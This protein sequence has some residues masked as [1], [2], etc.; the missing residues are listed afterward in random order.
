MYCVTRQS[1]WGTGELVVE[2]SEGGLDYTNPDAL[3]AKYKGEFQEFS[4]PREAVDTAIRIGEEWQKVEPIEKILIAMGCTSGNTIPFEGMEMTPE[5]LLALK[6]E[7]KK[8]WDSL[9]KCAQCGKV[10]GEEKFGMYALYNCCSER[11]AERW[12]ADHVEEEE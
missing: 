8:I 5:N 10:M 3:S 12:F 11:C 9:E 6:E 2:I 7:A 1:Q 4:D